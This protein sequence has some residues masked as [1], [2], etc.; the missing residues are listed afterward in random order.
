MQPIEPQ[1]EAHVE[2]DGGPNSDSATVEETG[3]AGSEAGEVQDAQK[4][5]AAA[6]SSADST[7]GV[8]AKPGVGAA[9]ATGFDKA[10]FPLAGQTKQH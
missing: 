4:A 7:L 2:D 1:D 3:A 9:L 6:T 5:D 10:H 8:D